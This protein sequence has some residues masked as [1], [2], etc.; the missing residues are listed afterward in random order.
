MSLCRKSHTVFRVKIHGAAAAPY[1]YVPKYNCYYMLNSGKWQYL[2][3][4]VGGFTSVA[5]YVRE[6]KYVKL[7]KKDFP[8]L[9]QD[10]IEKHK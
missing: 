5:K 4:S 7:P 3:E 8:L 10:L 6:G 1:A 2:Y 9:T